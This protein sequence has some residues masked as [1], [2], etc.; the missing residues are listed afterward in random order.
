MDDGSPDKCGEICD[1][2]AKRDVR[3][4]VIHK[5]N[6]GI[7]DARNVALDMM[8]GKYVVCVGYAN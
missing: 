6:G 8:T 3:I 4:H 1:D 7:A 2:Y 5:E